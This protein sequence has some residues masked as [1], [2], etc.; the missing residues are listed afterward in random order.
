MG[1]LIMDK[2]QELNGDLVL[3]VFEKTRLA[4]IFTLNT[5]LN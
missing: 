1:K 2:A 5:V 3:A 4:A